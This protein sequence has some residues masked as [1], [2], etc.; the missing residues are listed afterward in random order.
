[1]FFGADGMRMLG[2]LGFAFNCPSAFFAFQSASCSFLDK[3]EFFV[4]KEEEKYEVL[5][6]GEDEPYETNC[7][8]IQRMRTH[9]QE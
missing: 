5:S 2:R 3:E 7:C 8:F 4:E 9:A 6:K 1:M